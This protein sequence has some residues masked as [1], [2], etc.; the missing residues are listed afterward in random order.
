MKEVLEIKIFLEMCY[1]FNTRKIMLQ[2]Q[3]KY[4]S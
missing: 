1:K 4:F 3:I 2:D